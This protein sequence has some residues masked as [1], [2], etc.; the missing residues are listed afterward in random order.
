MT[1]KEEE[2]REDLIIV[3]EEWC[4]RYHVSDDNIKSYYSASVSPF[5][6]CTTH[7]HNALRLQVVL[8]ELTKTAGVQILV[9]L[10]E[11]RVQI[12]RVNKRLI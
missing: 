3:T 2:G 8:Y 12:V 10:T 9:R 6:G 4:L 5:S 1:K 7:T 11:Q